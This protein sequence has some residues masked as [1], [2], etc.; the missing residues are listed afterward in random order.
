M[1]ALPD[2][3][4]LE[5]ATSRTSGF[6][7]TTIAD[8][9]NN[10]GSAIANQTNLDELLTAEFVW[11]YGSAP[12]ASKTVKVHLLYSVDGTNYEEAASH[13][14]VGVFSPAADTSTHRVVVIRD[15][16]LLPHAFKIHV[17]N[18]DTGQTITLTVNAYTHNRAITD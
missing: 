3:V 14:L 6:S 2:T 17:E 16:P 15:E 12:T 7:S 10:S 13:N 1:M 11:S 9:A 8:G 4:Q 18:V 5:A